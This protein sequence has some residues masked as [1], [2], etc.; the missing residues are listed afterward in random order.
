MKVFLFIRSRFFFNSEISLSILQPFI[1]LMT[2]G[3]IQN[4][5]WKSAKQ[6]SDSLS[7][8]YMHILIYKH[9]TV[10]Q[11]TTMDLKAKI[12]FSLTR[13]W[14][15]WKSHIQCDHCKAF[16]LLFQHIQWTYF[17]KHFQDAGLTSSW[18][19]LLLSSPFMMKAHTGC[20]TKLSLF[21]S[22]RAQED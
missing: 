16:S 13:H 9:C 10:F 5:A 7:F 17:L 6:A 1:W 3:H 12:S 18:S 21:M 4:E 19:Y 8:S 20:R 22:F 2:T 14:N 11:A 15:L